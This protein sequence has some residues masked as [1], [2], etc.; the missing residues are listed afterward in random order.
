MYALG[1]QHYP[2]S[3]LRFAEQDIRCRIVPGPQASSRAKRHTSFC[4][5]FRRQI[6]RCLFLYLERT[7][8]Q[9]AAG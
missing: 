8:G 5:N 7:N 4:C 6:R 1:L 3:R 9:R 2:C